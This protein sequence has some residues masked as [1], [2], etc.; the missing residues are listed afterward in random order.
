M[1]AGR[2]GT[3]RATG[4][5]ARCQPTRSFDDRRRR[6]QG[7][8]SC[9][10]RVTGGKNWSEYSRATPSRNGGR[11]PRRTRRVG[12]AGWIQSRH[13]RWETCDL[14]SMR[15]PSAQRLR[16]CHCAPSPV[17]GP[18]RGGARVGGVMRLYPSEGVA[19]G[20]SLN[21][22][23]RKTAI[24]RPLPAGPITAASGSLQSE[25]S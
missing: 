10:H 14:D 1:A 17:S 23:P 9:W 18:R 11:G 16:S 5:G 4:D 6:P 3:R 24:S 20:E 2:S 7:A 15:P 12:R 25:S 21:R 19:D 22:P 13:G 8:V